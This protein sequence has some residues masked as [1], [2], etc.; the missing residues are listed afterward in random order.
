MNEARALSK[1]MEAA[2]GLLANIGDIIGDDVELLSDMLEGETGL[3][4]AIGRAVKRI[5]EVEA[6][7]TGIDEYAK[8]LT[9]R[10]ARLKKQAQSLRTAVTV[11]MSIAGKDTM[12]LPSA[13]VTR[14]TVARGLLV[15]DETLIPSEFWIQGDPK[16]D[17][18]KL[19]EAVK[20]DGASIP[21]AGLDNGGETL[22]IRSK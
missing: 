13:T 6:L 19:A 11:A 4:E 7:T 2:K 3:F 5:G 8:E 22:A 1:E 12:E 10:K 14:R 17:K 18:K 15:T 16:L 20:E 9:S 21:G